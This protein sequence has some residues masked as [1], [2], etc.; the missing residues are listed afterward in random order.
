MLILLIFFCLASIPTSKTHLS[1]LHFNFFFTP[2]VKWARMGSTTFDNL[3]YIC[4][5]IIFLILSL[6]KL[7]CFI[8]DKTLFFSIFKFLK[9]NSSYIISAFSLL[10]ISSL[11]LVKI[12]LLFLIFPNVYYLFLLIY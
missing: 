9:F 6:S 10:V 11:I 12:N 1:I 7:F 3:S 8:I 4:S 5:L 2:E